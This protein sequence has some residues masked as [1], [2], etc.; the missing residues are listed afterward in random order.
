[1]G[2]KRLTFRS[3][4]SKFLT[5]YLL[6]DYFF[7][8]SLRDHLL[9]LQRLALEKPHIQFVPPPFPAVTTETDGMHCR[10]STDHTPRS[11]LENSL[12]F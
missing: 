11:S 6:E 8:I 5:E 10:R 1:M 9:D 4:I 3:T 2:M 7:L 12:A